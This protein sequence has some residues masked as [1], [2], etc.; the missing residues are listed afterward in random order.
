MS[1]HHMLPPIVHV[2]QPKPRKIENRK[3][4]IQV[5]AGG[6]VDD[7]AD[8]E[9]AHEFTGPGRAAGG[10]APPQNFAAIEG[11][12]EK[13]RRATGRLSENTLKAMLLAQECE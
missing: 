7:M 9:D 13:P 6:A 10:R 8:V 12:E 1:R 4:R 5:R 11:S 2:P 3:R